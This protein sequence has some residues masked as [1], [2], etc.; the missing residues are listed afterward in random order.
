MY[1]QMSPFEGAPEEFDQ[2][3]FAVRRDRTIG[4]AEGLAQNLVKEQ[5]RLYLM[6]YTSLNLMI[7]SLRTVSHISSNDSQVGI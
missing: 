4:P 2:T 3:I 7:N 1:D 6:I 5:Q